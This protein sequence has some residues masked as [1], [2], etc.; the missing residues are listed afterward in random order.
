MFLL[1]KLT[2]VLPKQLQP[3][4]KAVYP[5]VVALAGAGVSWATT[6]NLDAT[7]IRTAVGGIIL[8]LVSYGVPNRD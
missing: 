4:A 2:A 8:A 1:D 7:E 5:G 3:Y 6:G